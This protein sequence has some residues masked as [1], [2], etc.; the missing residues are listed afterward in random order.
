[1]A[2]NVD[3]LAK[4]IAHADVNDSKVFLYPLK[5]SEMETVKTLDVDDAGAWFRKVLALIGSFDYIDKFR[6]ERTALPDSFL[7]SLQ[8]GDLERL[9]EALCQSSFL[10]HVSIDVKVP[11]RADGE[12]A[13]GY[14]AKT[15]PLHIEESGRSMR[16]KFAS[17]A[18]EMSSPLNELLKSHESLRASALEA[19]NRKL[20]D[21]SMHLMRSQVDHGIQ[22]ARDRVRRTE[23]AVQTAEMTQK[24]A[25]AL[26][27]LIATAGVFLDRFDQR[28]EQADK[29]M[30]KQLLYA[31]AG[32]VLSA[33][34]ALSAL[35]VSLMSY[36]Q[37]QTNNRS[38]DSWQEDV[39]KILRST[40]DIAAK[41]S[42][43]ISKLPIRD[44]LGQRKSDSSPSGKR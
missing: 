4:P 15:L 13:V 30:R 43:A 11:S 12:S 44:D 8:E 2:F 18:K 1:M 28:S 23:A 27:N 34:F 29:D 5:T 16:E 39:A 32:I 36:F 25:I 17:I 22:I 21:D 37:D 9:A 42:D 41:Q 40:N 31:L 10:R 7:S 14:L 20:V 35:I 19:Q 38:N 24:S 6:A 33:V 26:S 3:Q